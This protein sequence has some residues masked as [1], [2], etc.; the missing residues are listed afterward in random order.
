MGALDRKLREQTQF[1]L[2]NVIESV[3][4]TCVMVTHDQEEAMT[5][6]SRIAVMN[7][8][9]VL[10]VGTPQEIY[11]QPNSRF[12]A[13]FIGSANLF[14]GQLLPPATDFFEGA[15]ADGVLRLA[16]KSNL[17]VGQQAAVAVQPEKIRL[18]G[19]QPAQDHTVFSATVREIAYLRSYSSIVLE[20]PGGRTVRVTEPAAH[21]GSDAAIIWN[22]PVFFWWDAAAPLLLTA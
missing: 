13:D 3:G 6:A 4:V 10:Q 19:F 8:G 1:E 5:M 15:T 21:P 18:S 11:D 2:V 12:V 20:T 17:P 16:G 14:E 9:R 22:D 7:H